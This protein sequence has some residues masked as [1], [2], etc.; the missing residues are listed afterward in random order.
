MWAKG[1]EQCTNVY[2]M[3]LCEMNGEKYSHIHIFTYSYS[4]SPVLK[5]FSFERLM[6][7]NFGNIQ[8]VKGLEPFRGKSDGEGE[9]VFLGVKV[10]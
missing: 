10:Q 6:R 9:Y 8:N 2:L 1:F 3:Y 5:T 7:H 4:H